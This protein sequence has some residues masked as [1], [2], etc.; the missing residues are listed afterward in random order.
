VLVEDLF[1]LFVGGNRLRKEIEQ[2]V[3][4]VGKRDRRFQKTFTRL[5]RLLVGFEVL[6]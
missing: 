3:R 2:V 6:Y 4:R 1:H 5:V